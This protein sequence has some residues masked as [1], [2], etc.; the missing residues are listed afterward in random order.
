MD[1]DDAPLY[2]LIGYTAGIIEGAVALQLEFA[3]CREDYASGEG[4]SQQFVMTPEAAIELGK[5][6]TERGQLAATSTRLV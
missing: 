4:E 5:V 2:P 1:D 3:T 6:L